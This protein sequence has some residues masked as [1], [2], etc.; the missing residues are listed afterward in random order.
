MKVTT[1]YKHNLFFPV[2]GVM[3]CVQFLYTDAYQRRSHVAAIL[4]D[5]H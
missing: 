5:I 1:S 3:E 2:R 4:K